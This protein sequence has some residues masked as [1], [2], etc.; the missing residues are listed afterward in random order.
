MRVSI[1]APGWESTLVCLHITHRNS[2]TLLE[3]GEVDPKQPESDFD[4]IALPP[5]VY[6]DR[7][8]VLSA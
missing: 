2:A 5:R 1:I 6:I 8:Y 4:P 3:K 7:K